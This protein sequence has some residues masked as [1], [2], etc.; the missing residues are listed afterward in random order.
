MKKVIITG[1]AGFVGSHLLDLL[2]EQGKWKVCGVLRD[3][4]PIDKIRQHSGRV[5]LINCDLANR[6]STFK[7]IKTVK[8]DYIFHLAGESSVALSWGSPFSLLNNNVVATLNIFEAIRNSGK[9]GTRVM[10]ACSSDEYGLID[11]KDIPIE[12]KSPIKPVSPYAITKATVDMFSS[13]YYKSY[14]L[15]IIRIRAFNHT[16]PRRDDYYALSNFARQ[17]AE[18][19]AGKKENKL[20]V[21][22]LSAVRDYT[23]V[24]DMVRGYIFA[25]KKCAA[26]EVYNICSGKGY[27]IKKLLDT[28]IRLSGCKVGTIVDKS[29]MRPVDLPI[30]IGN[31]S[32]FSKV[33]KWKPCI[34]I[35][36]T[37]KDMLDYWYERV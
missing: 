32:K 20:Y 25:I 12:E 33:T 21:G 13:Y 35:E 36:Q 19:K 6:D 4:D 9:I 34:S 22:N 14:G 1:V 28:L 18:I 5:K 8:P 16:G 24:R 23:D 17:I 2:L 27:S 26:G 10:V 30:I 15:D 37:L 11:R 7:M 3:K 31:C 29:R